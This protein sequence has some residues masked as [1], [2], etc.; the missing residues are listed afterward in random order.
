M[1]KETILNNIFDNDPLDLLEIKAK[2]PIVTA[3]DRLIAS[4]EEINDFYEKNNCEP[5]KTTN[6]NERKL[7]SRLSGLKKD[8]NKIKSLKKYDKYNLLGCI[9]E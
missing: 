5:K 3:D 1:D 7:F 2:N 8:I 6:M 9:E 4:F